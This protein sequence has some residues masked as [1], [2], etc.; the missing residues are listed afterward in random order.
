MYIQ[1][2]INDRI[3]YMYNRICIY[4]CKYK[5]ISMCVYMYIQIVIND[6][7]YMYIRVCIYVHMYI[8]M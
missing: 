1:I 6:R 2:V 7:I 4:V 8:S 3:L 5:Y